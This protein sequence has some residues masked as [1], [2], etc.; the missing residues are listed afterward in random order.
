[1]NRVAA[2][3][4]ASTV[5]RIDGAL[6]EAGVEGRVYGRAK[7]PDSTFGKLLETDGMRVGDI[8]DMSGARVDLKMQR[9]GFEQ[10]YEARQA[11]QG[12][13]G[14]AYKMGKNYIAHPIAWEY[15]GRIHD[16]ISGSSVPN[17]ELQCDS[18]DLS[19]FIDGKVTNASGQSRS[20]HDLTGYKG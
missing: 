4:N 13:M 6:R 7:S 1:M 10:V 3:D 11:V 8:K 12:V 16:G 9:P 2:R 17:S 15:T 19:G 20:V 18:R 14:D 5:K